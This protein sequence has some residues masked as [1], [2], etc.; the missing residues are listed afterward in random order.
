MDRLRKVVCGT[1]AVL[2]AGA[3]VAMASG[4]AMAQDTDANGNGIGAASGGA[5]L[6][7]TYQ[8]GNA[9]GDGSGQ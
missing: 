2:T 8:V 5:D 3:V 1:L 9:Q 4:L 7:P 6:T